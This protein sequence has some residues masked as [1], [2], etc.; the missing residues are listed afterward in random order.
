LRDRKQAIC[1]RIWTLMEDAAALPGARGR[2]PNFVG[3]SIDSPRSTSGA[4]PA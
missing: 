2:I 1:D 3:A 4:A